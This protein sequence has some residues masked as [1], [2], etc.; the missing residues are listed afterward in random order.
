MAASGQFVFVSN[1][2]IAPLHELASAIP[3]VNSIHG[4]DSWK[5]DCVNRVEGNILHE[6]WTQ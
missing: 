5:G 1:S 2:A 3:T 6:T 4:Q